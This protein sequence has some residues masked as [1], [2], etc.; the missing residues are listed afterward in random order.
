M[1]L[2]TGCGVA[3]VAAAVVA[4]G[5]LVPGFAAAAV[6]DPPA[7]ALPA[8]QSTAAC[9]GPARLLDGSAAGTDP[10]FSAAASSSSSTVTALVLSS[11]DGTIP[12]SA[13]S[14]LGAGEPL[15]LLAPAAPAGSGSAS[16]AGTAGA[17]AGSA[18]TADNRK[19]A[20][21]KSQ[22]VS[23]ATVLRADPLGGKRALIGAVM[24]YA[25][26]DGDL[27][28]L[29]ADSCQPPAND[30]WLAG[31]STTVGRTAILN[32]SN[33][34]QTAATVNL[35]LFGDKGPVQAPGAKG[36]LVPAGTS[37]SVV[38]A[39]LAA[40][41]SNLSMRLKST[42]GPVA[43]TIQQSVLRGLTSGG[44]E[45]ISPVSA[46]AARQVVTGVAV[47]EPALATAVAGQSGY[48]D[49]GAA[50]QVTVPGSTDALVQ[51]KVY[52]PSGQQQLPGG[53]VFT[54]K[55]GGV[56]ELSL[57]GLPAGTYTLD[58]GSDVAFTATAR[59][60][61]AIKDGE[62]V[63]FGSAAAGAKLGNGQLITVPQG[64]VSTLVF[65][66]PAG[67]AKVSLTPVS[68]SGA[69]LPVKT[70]DVAGGTTLT[71]DPAQLAGE[72][73]AGFVVSATGDAVYGAQLLGIKDKAAVSV[74]G[75]PR[76]VSGPQ[77]LKVILGY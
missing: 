13:L 40:G 22:A 8:G 25:A 23:G 48:S 10:Q 63:D 15:A 57:A 75:V 49:A 46:P 29:A 43:A 18:A 19:A 56:S 77:D 2:I 38:L 26:P 9:P 39:G 28:G 24:A 21:L 44:V 74:L 47:Q 4:G 17:T 16:A 70:V 69:F 50:L 20:V 3:V 68:L 59:V 32:I 55:A 67:R 7:V 73:V 62:P 42:G 27:A 52:G 5:S 37:R 41:Q 58:I 33:S 71:V 51:V 35:E 53:G 45:V 76:G 65:G 36:L 11:P 54:A 66:V 6:V 64:V 60:A 14:P 61:S 34:S 12:G 72:A 31:A 1:S 30:L